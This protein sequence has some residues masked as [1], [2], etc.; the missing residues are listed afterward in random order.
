MANKQLF[1]DYLSATPTPIFRH[2]GP[3]THSKIPYIDS[4]N[5]D[6]S[7]QGVQREVRLGQIRSPTR[8][9]PQTYSKNDKVRP[10]RGTRLAATHKVFIKKQTI[11]NIRNND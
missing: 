6:R 2:H 1:K 4:S 8:R 3:V 5:P 9:S 7:D 11:I 10:S